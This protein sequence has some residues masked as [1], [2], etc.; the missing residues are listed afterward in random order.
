MEGRNTV[1]AYYEAAAEA[2]TGSGDVPRQGGSRQEFE[3]SLASSSL[4]DLMGSLAHIREASNTYFGELLAAE[5]ER[6]RE[7][8]KKP[9]A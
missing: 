3:A 1:S 4:D 8:A 9:K 5:K 2:R 7:Q 6:V